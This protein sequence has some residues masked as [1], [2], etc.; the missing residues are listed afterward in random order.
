MAGGLSAAEEERLR[1]WAI[2]I[3]E[4]LIPGVKWRDEGSERRA[5]GQGGLSINKTGAWYHHAAGKGGWSGISLIEHLAGCSRADAE[6]RAKAWLSTHPGTGDCG[7]D[8]EGDINI[9]EYAR[10]IIAKAVDPLG[11]AAEVYLRSRGIAPPYPA[12]VKFLPH[13]RC[14]EG[15]IVGLLTAGGQVVGC[16]I[17]YL[18]PDGRKSTIPPFRRRIMVEKAP[19]AIF[20]IRNGLSGPLLACEGIEDS[21]SLAKLGRFAVIGLPGIG[22]LPHLPFGKGQQI[23][24]VRDGDA[25]D[26]P[27]DK[28]LHAGIDH[29]IVRGAEVDLTATPAGSDANAVLLESGIDGLAALVDG[30]TPAELSKPSGLILWAASFDDLDYESQRKAIALKAGIRVGTLDL[31]RMVQRR[32]LF[33]QANVAPPEEF[34]DEDVDIGEVLDGIVK[35]LKRYIV[36]TEADYTAAGLWAAHSY[37]L[38]HEKINL[39]V[40]PHLGIQARDYGCGKTLLLE[41]LSCLISNPRLVSGAT[42]SSMFRIID[43]IHPTFLIDEVDQLLGPKPDHDLLQ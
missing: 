3:V 40:S 41:I 29:L 37:L 17:G 26:S 38:H 23:T 13:A 36:A 8:G 30:A 7:A 18:D 24:V 10:E 28:A 1:S 39:T 6:E 9:A 2:E 4:M 11:T 22:T 43:A 42:A 31:Q 19:C 15:A 33:P 12:C 32:A 35:E 20:D 27:A 14:G 5:V 25:P 16:Q 34:L 21:I